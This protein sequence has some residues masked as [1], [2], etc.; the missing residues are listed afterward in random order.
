MSVRVLSRWDGFCLACRVD[1]PLVLTMTGPGGVKSWWNGVG[2]Y[3][4]DL[5]LTCGLCGRVEPVTWD[6][7]DDPEADLL[8]I[9]TV[10]EQAAYDELPGGAGD[11]LAGTV[12]SHPV[13]VGSE[14][15]GP[16]PLAL[17]P[18]LAVEVPVASPFEP[19]LLEP[20]PV[21]AAAAVSQE[22]TRRPPGPGPTK[23]PR[24]KTV[25]TQ[26]RKQEAARQRVARQQERRVGAS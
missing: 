8:L 17:P 10:E 24:Q 23:I 3:D 2:W 12:A 1:R 15:L 6:Q 18:E 9:E 20:A 16:V 25:S 13:R 14:P 22:H 4:R 7:A 19:A 11:P 21:E 5:H 26:Q